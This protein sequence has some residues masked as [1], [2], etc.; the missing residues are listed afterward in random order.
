MFVYAIF[1]AHLSQ[2]CISAQ[3]YSFTVLLCVWHIRKQITRKLNPVRVSLVRV[4]GWRKWKIVIC[5]WIWHVIVAVGM[6]THRI[7]SHTD[8]GQDSQRESTG[9]NE[10]QWWLIAPLWQ[11]LTYTIYLSSFKLFLND[12]KH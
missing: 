6:S 9:A 11:A 10:H 7:Y 8:S 1:C 5:R 3:I 2:N 4:L 12:Y